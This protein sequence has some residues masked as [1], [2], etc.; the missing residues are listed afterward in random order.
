VA[1]VNETAVRRF[2]PGESPLG[3]RFH[4]GQR[5]GG[6]AWITIV[7]VVSDQLRYRVGEQD[8]PEVY[9]SMLQP[10]RMQRDLSVVIHSAV[11]PTS[12]TST[13]RSVVQRFDSDLPVSNVHTMASALARSMAQP[14]LATNLMGTFALLTLVLAVV[15]LYGV[16]SYSVE[17]RTREIGVRVALGARGTDVV[18]LVTS[19]GV[20][21][22]GAGVVIGLGGAWLATRLVDSMLYGVAPTDIL[23]F[24]LLPLALLAVALLASLVPA[25]RA[26]HIAPTEAL[27][28]E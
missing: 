6:E 5:T 8:L 26:T 20:G 28:E 16:V 21:P 19:E 22:A 27:R 24:T 9:L 23:T 15:G 1:V 2:W 7:G 11:D 25:V 3:E 10:V 14:R 4:Y 12:L 13:V 17:G 18:R